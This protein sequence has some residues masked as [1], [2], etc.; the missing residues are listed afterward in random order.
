[1]DVERTPRDTSRDC[2]AYIYGSVV[3]S[4]APLTYDGHE[5]GPS[6]LNAVVANIKQEISHRSPSNA[7]NQSSSART[8][9]AVVRRFIEEAGVM[10][11]NEPVMSIVEMGVFIPGRLFDDGTG[12]VC[13]CYCDWVDRS[14]PCLK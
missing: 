9:E 8:D 10:C 5:R 11:S 1:M 3:P 6:S 4:P 12:T 7:S 14:L 2:D 13:S